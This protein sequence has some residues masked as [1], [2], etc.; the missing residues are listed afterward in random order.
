[1][2]KRL[3]CI[4]AMLMTAIVPPTFAQN[5]TIKLV[6]V[7]E[8]SGAG[9]T[10]GTNFKNGADLAV[11][12]VNATGGIQGRK[13]EISHFDTQSNAGVARAQ[14]QKALDENPYAILGPN[15][16]G[17]VKATAPMVKQA[18]IAQIMGGEAAELT[19]TG[20]TSLF[21][22]SFGQQS[23][24]PKIAKYIADDVKAK[25]VAVIWVNN[26]FGKGGRD[27]SSRNSRRAASRSWPTSRP[28][29]A[30][31]TSPPTC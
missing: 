8:L 9:A 1:M 6:N 23:S 17:L 2:R 27:R 11:A 24:M 18:G 14:M 30:R 26:D 10:V 19:Q 29:P 20:A 13:V 28:K 4:T 22:T 3:I 5:T 16:S 21:R 25:S 31:P 7:N 15:F 12:E